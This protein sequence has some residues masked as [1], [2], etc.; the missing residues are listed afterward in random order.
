MRT[1]LAA[2]AL[3]AAVSAP[4]TVVAVEYPWCAMYGDA[5]GGINCG[6]VSLAQCNATISGNGGTC[7]PNPFYAGRVSDQ[8]APRRSKR[9]Q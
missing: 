5:H 2:A 1:L 7:Q 3:L 4:Q 9:S 6:F 8:P